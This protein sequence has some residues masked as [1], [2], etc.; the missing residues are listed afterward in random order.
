MAS[1]A[2]MYIAEALKGLQVIYK[3]ISLVL[4]CGS[5]T[6]L[7][8]CGET[9]SSTATIS[10]YAIE[11]GGLIDIYVDASY[12]GQ[13]QHFSSDGFSVDCEDTDWPKAYLGVGEYF[14]EYYRNG[15][16]FASQNYSVTSGQLG[17]C[18]PIVAYP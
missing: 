1:C 8:G 9:E 4:L 5:L 15:S 14:I 11:D 2:I 6:F 10:F 16:R 7:L 12:V 18:I 17:G 13:I 3:F